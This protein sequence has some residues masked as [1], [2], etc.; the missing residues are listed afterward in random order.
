M[1]SLK[2]SRQ[3]LL[4]SS[5]LACVAT[6]TIGAISAE[7]G[8]LYSIAHTPEVSLT[9]E[10]D[11]GV[12]STDN[13]TKNNKPTFS[14]ANVE[15]GYSIFG[16]VA[17]PAHL[18]R[19]AETL[20][21]VFTR[22]VGTVPFLW[23][24]TATGRYTLPDGSHRFHTIQ[25][26]GQDLINSAEA[27]ITIVIDTVAPSNLSV[28]SLSV[29]E[30]TVAVSVLIDHGS[31]HYAEG[32]DFVFGGSCSPFGT[33]RQDGTTGVKTGQQYTLT[34]EAENGS[35]ADCT[36]KAIDT[37]GNESAVVVID[38]F[39]IPAPPK[40]KPKPKKAKKKWGG[41]ALHSGDGTGPP[42]IEN[43]FT[44]TQETLSKERQAKILALMK[45][46]VVLLTELREKIKSQQQ[47]QADKGE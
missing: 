22:N 11:T 21:L 47:S 41:I 7:A 27:E 12:S 13:I 29:V 1:I 16:V 10:T 19:S 14:F 30:K 45:Q 32:L 24:W 4:F 43:T 9:P 2:L 36:V 28:Q 17:L 18:G 23:Q 39:T 5:L 31:A 3:V 20:S 40:P 26:D 8:H 6:L 35:Y 15:L 38:P 44:G 42:T 34:I 46:V 37:A 33:V 25:T